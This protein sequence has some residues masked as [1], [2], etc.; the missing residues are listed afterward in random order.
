MKK[1]RQKKQIE[2]MTDA[3]K[4]VRSVQADDNV[5]ANTYLSKIVQKKCEKRFKNILAA[6]KNTGKNR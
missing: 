1:K 6:E 5:A 4:F 2:K 3:E